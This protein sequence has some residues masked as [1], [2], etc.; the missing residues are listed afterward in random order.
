MGTCGKN[1]REEKL[2]SVATVKQKFHV[3]VSDDIAE[4]ILIG[5]YA[6]KAHKPT[7]KSAFGTIK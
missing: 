5:N 6:A 4:A 7:L 3:N 1:R 2:L